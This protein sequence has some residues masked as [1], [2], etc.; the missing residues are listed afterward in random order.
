MANEDECLPSR[1]VSTQAQLRV[2]LE[3]CAGTI[4]LERSQVGLGQSSRP[5]QVGVEWGSTAEFLT[6]GRTL[7]DALEEDLSGTLPDPQSARSQVVVVGNQGVVVE[8]DFTQWDSDAQFSMP[9]RPSEFQSQI[10]DMTLMDS[11]TSPVVTPRD[12]RANGNIP[13][14]VDSFTSNRFAA[15][16]ED[17]DPQREKSSDESETLSV[18]E[19][20]F[21]DRVQEVPLFP[22]EDPVAQVRHHQGEVIEDIAISPAI[23]TA[24]RSLD[25]VDV[26]H[27]FRDR[28]VIMKSLPTLIRGAYKSAMRMALR[29]AADRASARD[30]PG[31]C[32]A[33]K[34]FLLLPRMLLFRPPRGGFVHK[35]QLT[36]RFARF[37]RGQWIELLLASQASSENARRAQF[38]RNRTAV[39]SVERRA[40]RAFCLAQLG[41]LSSARQALEGDAVALGND[42]TL[43][44]LRDPLR[45]PPVPRDPLPAD[46]QQFQPE[47][48]FSLEQ[49]QLLRNLRVSRRGCAAGPSGMTAD[50]L[51]PLLESVQDSELLWRL[52]QGLAR[53][54]VPLEVLRVVKMG[55]VT[56]LRKP[57]G[58]IRGIVVG[59]I[60]R[61][62][63]AR[64]ISQ[65]ITPAVEVATA[66]FQ[67]ALSTRAG[68]KCVSHVLQA[69]CCQSMVW[70]RSTSCRAHP[71]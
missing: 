40:E 47:V 32:R 44:A 17:D 67:Y 58:G 35:C 59:D 10:V 6:S 54:E 50:H 16:R 31:L 42:Q 34:L 39:D 53:A 7:L 20:E 1:K 71:C 45:R 33:W 57:T 30:E 3:G 37:S 68:T 27:L 52:C 22:R 55:R 61:R 24:L 19:P 63:V 56:A 13:T 25:E 69:P 4:R 65:Q 8:T 18:A 62:L 64:T 60:L 46:L 28:A 21:V 15:L 23:R 36:E 66:P 48:Q 11:D 49:D 9:S 5:S 41:E 26:Q 70:V 12:H 51:R 14:P 29:E 38:R 2:L 43:Q